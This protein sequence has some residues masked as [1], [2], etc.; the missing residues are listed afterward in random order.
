MLRSEQKNDRRPLHQ[1]PL[2]AFVSALFTSSEENNHGLSY[3]ILL[4]RLRCHLQSMSMSL[5]I[6]LSC[7]FSFFLH[8][9]RMSNIFV[10]VCVSLGNFYLDKPLPIDL[11]RSTST[12]SLDNIITNENISTIEFSE[13]FAYKNG[14]LQRYQPSWRRF[15]FLEDFTVS[16]S[17]WLGTGTGSV[18]VVNLNIIYEPRNISGKI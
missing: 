15:L 18:I 11:P 4:R 1:M 14:R 6:Y 17:V 12:S 9:C 2:L 13:T 16:P 7:F 10:Y 5:S 8:V 3:A